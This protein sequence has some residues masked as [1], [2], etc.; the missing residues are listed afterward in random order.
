MFNIFDNFIPNENFICNDKDPPLFNDHIKTLTE[1]KNH[2]F[3]RCMA[4]DS[5]AV[6]LVRLQKTGA[7]LI[8]III[9]S[10][11]ANFYNNHIIKIK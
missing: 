6:D 9:T 10:K 11:K 2:F 1:K 5:L 4:N 3:K 7:E 8:N